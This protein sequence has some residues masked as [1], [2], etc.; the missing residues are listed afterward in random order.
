MTTE[1]LNI[2]VAKL[3]GWKV[4]HPEGKNP[5]W[6]ITEPNGQKIVMGH[7]YSEAGLWSLLYRMRLPRY[8]GNLHLAWPLLKEIPLA[9]AFLNRML[10]A[11]QSPEDVAYYLCS[12]YVQ[13]NTSTLI[14]LPVEY[15]YPEE[16]A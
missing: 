11:D 4:N 1:E 16:P 9:L 8:T 2:A 15:P 7:G 10:E 13:V 6:F 5:N 12:M 14:P 3:Q